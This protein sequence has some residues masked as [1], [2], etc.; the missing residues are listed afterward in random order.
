MTQHEKTAQ[1][2]NEVQLP[3]GSHIIEYIRKFPCKP[4]L[5]HTPHT[6]V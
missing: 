5:P 1:E 4:Y 3:F 2:M 6:F